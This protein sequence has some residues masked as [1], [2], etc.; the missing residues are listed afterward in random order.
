[1]SRT[2]TDALLNLP[3]PRAS[4]TSIAFSPSRSATSPSSTSFDSARALTAQLPVRPAPPKTAIFKGL[5]AATEPVVISSIC[6]DLL[7]RNLLERQR[8][9]YSLAL[10]D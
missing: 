6:R 7:G 3:P 4:D 10:P 1:M 9:V 2:S 5:P 8:E